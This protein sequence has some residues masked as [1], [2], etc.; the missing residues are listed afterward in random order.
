MGVKERKQREKEQR[1]REILDAARD[2]VMREGPGT[3]TMDRVAE[4]TEL[5]KGT[6]Y[7]YFPSRSDL[8]GWLVVEF[9]A[10]LAGAMREAAVAREN[11]LEALEAV[12]RAY[13][14]YMRGQAPLAP[15]IEMAHTSVFGEGLSAEVAAC[16]AEEGIG[17]FRLMSELVQRAQAQ[18]LVRAEQDPMELSMA[19]AAA[20]MGVMQMRTALAGCGLP[21]APEQLL[22]RAWTL[23]LRSVVVG[24]FPEPVPPSQ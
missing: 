1:R 5:S 2:L 17:P 8:L 13:W 4:V 16:L 22:V 24:E 9:N 21:I 12:G 11:P 15:L 3:L 18:G 23:I 6:L 20:S 19:L 14:S 7:L 10:G